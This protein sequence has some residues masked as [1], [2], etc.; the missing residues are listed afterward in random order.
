MI[1]R[2]EERLEIKPEKLIG[3]TAYGAARML[4]WLVD[5]QGITPHVPVWDKSAGKANMIVHLRFQRRLDQRLGQRARH[6]FEIRFRSTPLAIS[7]AKASISS[8][9]IASLCIP[10][11]L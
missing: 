7:R 6:R 9:F 4:G 5:E 11:L 1:E 10:L 2:V 3:D 8:C